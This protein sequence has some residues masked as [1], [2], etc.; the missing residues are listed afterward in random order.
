MLIVAVTFMTTSGHK[1]MASEGI[2]HSSELCSLTCKNHYVGNCPDWVKG[3]VT[4]FS[5][6]PSDTVLFMIDIEHLSNVLQVDGVKSAF[7]WQ[8]HP[9]SLGLRSRGHPGNTGTA[10]E[11]PFAFLSIFMLSFK[12]GSEP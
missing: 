8:C 1:Q 10:Y 4:H 9:M 11:D 12:S 7:E 6:G 5:Q 2:K 3:T